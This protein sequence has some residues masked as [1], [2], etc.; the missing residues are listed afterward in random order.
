M[1]IWCRPGNSTEYFFSLEEVTAKWHP[2]A[3]Q[4]CVSFGLSGHR[5]LSTWAWLQGDP[6]RVTSVLWSHR[7]LKMAY[8]W[9]A[10]CYWKY[11]NREYTAG[12]GFSCCNIFHSVP[13]NT[14]KLQ[15][16]LGEPRSVPRPEKSYSK[17][18]GLLLEGHAW[19][20][21]EGRGPGGIRCLNHPNWI[22]SGSTPSSPRMIEL[23][24]IS[25]RLSPATQYKKII[26]SA[27]TWDL[28]LLV[29]IHTSWPLSD[30]W[31]VDRPVNS[32]L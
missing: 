4:R 16:L 19:E 11:W 10:G 31:N 32:E 5:I 6:C 12:V 7:I 24:F 20:T 2:A 29:L 30:G 9:S 13:I 28:V 18:W 25:P 1:K 27:C 14:E 23:F 3:A 22:N 15:L 21:S 26:L 17:F 8:H